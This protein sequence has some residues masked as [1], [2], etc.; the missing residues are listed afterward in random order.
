MA[1][2]GPMVPGRWLSFRGHHWSAEMVAVG[3]QPG[4]PARPVEQHA[5]MRALT[6]LPP[7]LFGA[8]AW[9]L[10]VEA[11]ILILQGLCP[12]PSGPVFGKARHFQGQVLTAPLA[13]YEHAVVQRYSTSFLRYLPMSRHQ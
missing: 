2:A 5:K 13:F 6:T 11:L 9:T 1:D 4:C 3:H 12:T 8:A 10:L 7:D